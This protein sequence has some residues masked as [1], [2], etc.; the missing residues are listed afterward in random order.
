MGSKTNRHLLS[1]PTIAVTV[2]CSTS[3]TAAPSTVPKSCVVTTTSVAVVAGDTLRMKF[4]V[5][6]T[7]GADILTYELDGLPSPPVPRPSLSCQLFDG[8][9]LLGSDGSCSDHWQSSTASVR[10]PGVPLIDFS[11]IA[12]G[13]AAACVDYIITGGSWVFDGRGT[14]SLLRTT[15][16]DTG[17]TMTYVA[18]GT[19]SPLE[20]ISA[21]CR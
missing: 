11:T 7:T 9:H 19:T 18:A 10:L 6:P 16:T 1:L 13:T 5:P 20:L 21:S 14:V 15:M 4:T 17:P 8:D 3:P 12:A 2:S